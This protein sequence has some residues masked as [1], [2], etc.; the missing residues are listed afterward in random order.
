MHCRKDVDIL[1][2]QFDLVNSGTI[3]LISCDSV[4]LLGNLIKGEEIQ[5]VSLIIPYK[6]GNGEE[7][8]DQIIESKTVEGILAKISGGVF[9]KGNGVLTYELVGVPLSFG[10]AVFEFIIGRQNCKIKLNV[11]EH[12]YPPNFNACNG[13]ITQ[14]VD[15]L[16]PITGRVWM[17]RNLGALRPAESLSDKDAFGDLYQWGRF[18]DGHQCRNSSTTNTL[19]NIERPEH[20]NFIVTIESPYDWLTWQN[21]DLWKGVGIGNNPCPCGYRLPTL[22]EFKEEAKS[23]SSQNA[24]G[25][26]ASTLK[27]PLAGHRHYGNGEIYS[28]GVQ[29]YYWTSDV[30]GDKA[31]DFN[32]NQNFL[33][34]EAIFRSDGSSVRCIKERL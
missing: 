12:L 15:V 25:A 19:S 1:D 16:N 3:E 11:Y 30:E 34:H 17:D 29:G 28:T 5:D 14:V 13:E 23:W 26:Y 7:Y 33:K 27:L 18:A 24:T 22:N 20:S 32:I 9:E 10:E 21:D 4:F 6:D 2:G 31:M 8:G